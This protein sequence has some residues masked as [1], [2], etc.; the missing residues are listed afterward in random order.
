MSNTEKE[1]KTRVYN[2]FFNSYKKATAIN[3]TRDLIFVSQ[4][5]PKLHTT[6]TIRRKFQNIQE[7]IKSLNK[8]ISDHMKNKPE[9]L[10]QEHPLDYDFKTQALND[11]LKKEINNTRKLQEELEAI[12]TKINTVYDKYE[13]ICVEATQNSNDMK[14]ALKV[15]DY[16]KTFGSINTFASVITDD[17][18]IMLD[19]KP[20]RSSAILEMCLAAAWKFKRSE[21]TEG[22][23]ILNTIYT[24]LG[25]QYF[26]QIQS[27][28]KWPDLWKDFY[29]DMLI[30]AV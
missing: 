30:L 29:N 28:I 11:S 3:G 1:S 13:K 9:Q 7:R 16:K 10:F 20:L 27:K 15:T 25:G 17:D 5:F 23:E 4:F 26:K 22:Y 12:K 18:F 14:K 6:D 21:L 24:H 2:E 8:S 19:N